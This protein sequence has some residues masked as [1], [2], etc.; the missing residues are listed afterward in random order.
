MTVGVNLPSGKQALTQ[1]EFETLTLL[2]RNQYDFQTPSFGLGLGVSPGLTL[3]F[4]LSEAVV[5]G[6]GA[7]YQY[8]GD[9]EPLEDMPDTY[10][11]GDELLITGGLDVRFGLAVSFS[12]DVTYATYRADQLGIEE[13]FAAGDKVLVGGQLRYVGRLNQFRL[14]ARYR[15]RARNSLAAAGGTLVE[16]D[17]K[18]FPDEIEVFTDHRTRLAGFLY[19]SVLGEARFYNETL[20]LPDLRALYGAGLGLELAVSPHVH[21]PAWFL[22][23]FGDLTGLEAVFGLRARL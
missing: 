16:E 8:R 11:P 9:F 2:S 3:A 10:R 18:M 5:I 7:A 15:S 19:G 6:L 4:P 12:A 20:L 17:E 1:E 14:A 13:V 23:Q 22:Y 21:F